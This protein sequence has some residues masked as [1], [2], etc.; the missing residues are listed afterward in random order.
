MIRINP[1]LQLSKN[2]I[3][4]KMGMTDVR[5]IIGQHTLFVT[6]TNPCINCTYGDLDNSL[7]LDILRDLI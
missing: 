1:P 6:D 5:C 4:A 7:S 2:P 3:K